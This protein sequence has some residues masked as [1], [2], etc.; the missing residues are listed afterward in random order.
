MSNRDVIFGAIRNSGVV[1]LILGTVFL[2]VGIPLLFV[3]AIGFYEQHQ[4]GS[5]KPVSAFVEKVDWHEEEGEEET[6]YHVTGTYRYDWEGKTY[7]CDRI[8][9]SSGSTSDKSAWQAIYDSF[10]AS[11]D[12]GTPI[13]V[14][15]DP[16]SPSTAVA[17]RNV[18]IG[19]ILFSFIGAMFFTFGTV[20]AAGGIWSALQKRGPADPQR[21]WIGDGPWEGFQIRS[22]DWVDVLLAWVIAIC[23]ALFE[24]IFIMLMMYDE[25][26]PFLAKGIL[27]IFVFVAIL[28][29]YNAIYMTLRRLKYGNSLLLLSQMPLV[30]GMAFDAVVVSKRAL[31]PEDGCKATLRCVAVVQKESTGSENEVTFA[32][33]VMYEKS[34]VVRADLTAARGG[35]SA[36][37]VHFEI[38]GHI[39]P[40]FLQGYPQIRWKLALEAET[41]GIDYFAEFDLPVYLASDPTM[42][43]YRS[44]ES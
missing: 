23:V 6:A 3:G 20:F 21:P 1:F 35:R 22:G 17:F 29:I 12:G 36:V 38:P 8:S 34:V 43:Q 4:S 37:P 28:L 30:P 15:V 44:A 10:K 42:I 9:L 25:S 16:N 26:V 19:M 27:I 14:Y 24:S 2:L 41:T 11:R 5:W 13:T 40:R 7:R 31:R 32:E 33:E 39:P 18:T